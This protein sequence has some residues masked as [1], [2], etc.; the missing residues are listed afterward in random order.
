MTVSNL[1]RK[2]IHLLNLNT[3]LED[4]E[5]VYSEI[6]KGVSFRGTNLWILMFA[7]VIASVGLNMN[8]TAVIIGAMLIS[9]LMGP[10]NGMGYGIAT[11]DLPLFRKAVKN[12]TFAIGVGLVASTLYFLITPISTAQS[13]LLART[14]PTIYDVFI[15]LF[16]GLAGIVAISSQQKGTVIPGVAIATALMPPLC[17]AGYGLANLKF[18]FFF[19]A[20]YLFTINTIFIALS[21]VLVSQILKFPIRGN[22]EQEKK[23][24]IHNTITIIIFVVMVP[25]I[26]FGYELVQR[27]R[28]NQI[29]NN[30][31]KSVSYIEGN[32]LL[33]FNI[34]PKARTIE[35][36]YGGIALSE[37]QKNII[38]ANAKAFG[39]ESKQILIRQGLMIDFSDK[40]GDETAKLKEKINSLQLA[41]NRKIAELDSIH[42]RSV[43]G[44]SIFAE[45]K[46]LYP[47]ISSLS[48]SE[49]FIYTDTL[50]NPI[51]LP[52]IILKTQGKLNRINSDKIE[53]WL[54][55]RLNTDVVKVSF[56]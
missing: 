45:L 37:A 50:Q 42:Q 29:G 35:L 31:A 11:F 52:I 8:S 19:G 55:Q 41:L 10:I 56:E 9:P 1:Y 21:S 14:N 6:Q 3:H 25:S 5:V 40:T 53:N 34:D 20:L 43:I 7:V 17:T 36:V 23:L 24:R 33:K 28:F 54:K 48:F 16:G 39:L 47:Q 49:G 12:F 26:Y 18:D 13:E 27:E 22:I 51:K 30:Y 2:I 32:Y 15:A 46:I 44:S 38:L 4:P